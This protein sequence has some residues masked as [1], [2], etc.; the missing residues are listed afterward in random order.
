MR[1]QIKF[2]LMFLL[3]LMLSGCDFP[4]IRDIVKCCNEAERENNSS[5]NY[6]GNTSSGNTSSGNTSSGNTSSGNTS[7][8]NTSSGNTSSGNT[9]SGNTSSGNTQTPE[10]YIPKKY[11]GYWTQMDNGKEYYINSQTVKYKDY[12]W[13]DLQDGISGFTLE[14]E[15]VLI[16]KNVPLFRKHGKDRSFSA[17]ISGFSDSRAALATKP[18]KVKRENISNK[19]DKQ[20]LNM[21]SNATLVFTGAVPG[22]EQKISFETDSGSV[23][24]EATLPTVKYDGENIGTIPVIPDGMYGFKTTY[25]VNNADSQGFM[26]G[27]YYNYYEIDFNLTNIGKATCD[28]SVYE[29]SWDDSNLLVS[30][31]EKNGNFSSIEP[32][33]A[34]T[35][36]GKF[37]Y[38][39]FTEEYKDVVLNIKITDSRYN[40]TWNDSV[41]L[42]FYRGIVNLK[43]NARN[44][45]ESS[46]ATLKGFLIYPDG[47]S[48]RFTVGHNKTETVTVPWSKSDYYLVFSGASADN[49]MAYSFSFPQSNVADLNGIWTLEEINSYESNNTIAQAYNVS[50]TFETIKSYLKNGDIDYY[51]INNSSQEPSAGGLSYDSYHICDSTDVSNNN[52]NDDSINPGETIGMDVKIYNSGSS[53]AK[54]INVKVSSESE[55]ITFTSDTADFENISA[56]G[57]KTY[58][59]TKSYYDGFN[60]YYLPFK[61][62]VSESCPINTV[63][64]ITVTMTDSYDTVWTDSFDINV[65]KVGTE[66]EYNTHYICDSTSVSSNNNDDDSINPGETIGIDVKIYNSGSSVAKGINV[67]VSSESEYITFTSDTA[68][69]EDIRAQGYN[70]YYR[71]EV[72]YSTSDWFSD[73]YLPFKFTVSESC[74]ID[75]VI[76]I[77][78]TMTDSYDNVWTDSFDINVVKVGTELEYNA[79]HICDSTDVSSNNNNDDSINPGETIGIDVKIYNSGSSVAKGINVKVSSESEYITFTSDT[80][81]FEDIRAGNYQS[82]YVKKYGGSYYGWFSDSYLPFK[83]TVSESCPINTVIPITVTMTDSYDN[84]W[85][86]SFD[87]NVVKPDINLVLDNYAIS[88][89]KSAG[90]NNND[91]RNINAGECIYMDLR[92][93]NKGTVQAKDVKI[94]LSSESPYITFDDY[95]ET[96][97]TI[98]G[99]YYATGYSDNFSSSSY[100]YDS[101]LSYVASSPAYK[102]SIDANTPVGSVITIDVK[103]TDS[104][105]TQWTDTIDITVVEPYVSFKF[106]GYS[107]SDATNY[108]GDNNNDK[109]INELE[110]IYMDIGIHNCGTTISKAVTVTLS[111]TSEYITFTKSSYEYKSLYGGYYSTGYS[112]NKTSLDSSSYYPSKGYFKF[113]VKEGAAGKTVPIK[114]TFTDTDSNTWTDTF[115][116]TIY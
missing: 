50:N 71:T 52:N 61:F 5:N 97:G 41:T 39:N 114:V 92:V 32:G 101:S 56:Q 85:T 17:S 93:H 40:Q 96:L 25:S 90:A 15:N 66:L 9:S 58:Y 94:R 20:T 45:D 54:G 13:N 77:S 80:A 84:V 6:Q 70:T 110:T 59:K 2:I 55:Y 102:F 86:D 100:N 57:Y 43:V 29:V 60:D 74:P 7:S 49:E 98:S 44:F 53:V 105:G 115:N 35:I 111:T 30:D 34:K 12:Y 89:T 14:S 19:E 28:T 113:T 91:D 8:G 1:K 36:T 38:K 26:Y 62:T 64:P 11:W 37:G 106:E 3:P 27:N 104:F 73:S 10:S 107:I 18:A 63:I 95:S 87:I 68:D 42:R 76:P 116:F 79:H 51:K 103:I 75:T 88:D 31:F 47:R 72:Y 23:I 82:Y 24:S 33:K 22:D 112:S 46:N 78:V 16:Y 83:F 4:V 81:D 65:V 109:K 21:S 69:F 108:D 67:K 99:G 48:K